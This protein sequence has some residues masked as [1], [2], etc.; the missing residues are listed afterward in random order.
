MYYSIY[1]SMVP[2]TAPASPGHLLEDAREF[3]FLQSLGQATAI[4]VKQVLRV[5]Q[6]HPE[7]E[8]Q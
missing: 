5:I 7:F 8:D 6:R 1:Q 3:P 4:C 2:G